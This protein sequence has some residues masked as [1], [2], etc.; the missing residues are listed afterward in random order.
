MSKN[1]KTVRKSIRKSNAIGK[2]FNQCT[3]DTTMDTFALKFYDEQLPNG[4]ERLKENIQKVDKRSLQVL[5]IKHDKDTVKESFWKV[6]AEKPHYH[7]IGRYV[8]GKSG[9]KLR[10]ILNAFEIVYRD[11]EDTSLLENHGAEKCGD[12]TKYAVYLTHETKEAIMGCKHKYELSEVISN[13]SYEEIAMIREGYVRLNVQSKITE[14]DMEVL[15]DEAIMLAR[16][17]KDFDDWLKDLPLKVQ[18][19]KEMAR[20]RAIYNDEL[21][22]TLEK[23]KIDRICIYIHE[24]KGNLGK[25]YTSREALKKLGLTHIHSISQS[26]GNTGKYDAIR[27]GTEAII[28]DDASVGEEV[29]SIC[30]TRG[31]ALYRRNSGLAPWL[32][33]WVIICQNMPLRDWL[34]QSGIKNSQLEAA[35]TRFFECTLKQDDGHSYLFCERDSRRG[36]KKLYLNKIE[37]YKQFKDAFNEIIYDYTPQDFESVLDELNVIPKRML[38]P[39]K[40]ETAYIENASDYL[41]RKMQLVI[42]GTD[43]DIRSKL[44]IDS[45]RTIDFEI[46]PM[47]DDE[48]IVVEKENNKVTI[49]GRYNEKENQAKRVDLSLLSSAC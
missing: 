19:R 22:D 47:N 11:P 39:F 14:Q 27:T 35:T 4:F 6:S 10:S 26:E 48:W 17:L 13:C 12:F 24:P 42:W 38:M 23:I 32:G 5:C 46:D 15:K 41:A 40:S 29:M 37:K 36:D 43:D 8:N 3:M 34:R 2:N 28:I 16:E 9:V 25:S 44:N 18:T 21:K 45:H 20:I 33:Q 30:D 1:R 31:V 7:L 49:I